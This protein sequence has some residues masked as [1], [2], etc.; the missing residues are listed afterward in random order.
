[1]KEGY[2]PMVRKIREETRAAFPE[3]TFDS[4]DVSEPFTALLDGVLPWRAGGMRAGEVPA[5]QSIYA[6]HLQFVGREGW[7]E[8]SKFGKAARQLLYGEQIGWFR[9]NDVESDPMFRLFV[10][11]LA[12]TRHAFLRCFNHGRMLKP[13]TYGAAAPVVTA[14]WGYRSALMETT[15]AIM[16]GVWE[17]DGFVAALFVNMTHENKSVSLVPPEGA[18]GVENAPRTAT[19]LAEGR[20]S[21]ESSWKPGDA[22][23]VT[24]PGYGVAAWIIPKKAGAGLSDIKAKAEV[25]FA[26]LAGF[27]KEDGVTADSKRVYIHVRDPWWPPED[28]D[29]PLKVIEYQNDRPG[30]QVSPWFPAAGVRRLQGAQVTANSNAPTSKIVSHVK[31]GAFAYYGRVDLGPAK[32]GKLWIEVEVGVD[33]RWG[34]VLGIYAARNG[35]GVQLSKLQLEETG[36][37]TQFK[38]QR[39]LLEPGTCGVK[40]L[41]FQFSGGAGSGICN[42]SRWRVVREKNSI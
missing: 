42:F 29:N 9:P 34:G 27:E 41:I 35:E 36:G 4:E 15:P 21:Q 8:T 39:F 18:W 5:F 2:W 14:D 28:K 25:L 31:A 19:F 10:K 22:V 32:G 38:T 23:N 12:H 30:L 37:F 16:H 24:V 40:N 6:G 26:S 20:S 11:K 17:A 13:M 7:R 33:K 1:V 3:T